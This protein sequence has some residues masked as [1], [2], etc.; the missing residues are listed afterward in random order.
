MQKLNLKKN[1]IVQI[2]IIGYRTKFIQIIKLYLKRNN[3]NF[4]NYTEKKNQK[5]ENRGKKIYTGFNLF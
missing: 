3:K 4:I 2:F 5:R 1:L